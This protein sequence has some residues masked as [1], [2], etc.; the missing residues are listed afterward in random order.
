MSASHPV[1]LLVT[2]LG[3]ASI[4]QFL[5]E[6]GRDTGDVEG[7]GNGRGVKRSKVGGGQS[8]PPGGLEVDHNKLFFQ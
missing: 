1:C 6:F 3:L 5:P 7:A 8:G 4:H 2:L